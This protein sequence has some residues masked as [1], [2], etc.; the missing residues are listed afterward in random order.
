VLE[1][2]GRVLVVRDDLIPG[3][4]KTR[5]LPIL[6]E[7]TTDEVVYATPAYGHAQIALAVT[8]QRMGKRLTL[9][10]AE[11]KTYTP[12]TIK[13]LSLGADMVAIP[14]GY[15]SN[16]QSKAMNYATSKGVTLLPF[17]L[18]CEP[19]IA[20]LTDVVRSLNVT[21]K[22]VWAA[23]GSGTLARALQRAWPDAKHRVVVVGARSDFGTAEVLV[24]PE[25]YDQ[26]A[27]NPPPFPSAAHYD[28]KVWQFIRQ[29]PDDPKPLFWNVAG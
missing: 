26:K 18:L 11:R 19:F 22:T 24:A 4:T 27:S 8:C 20:A 7:T 13:A 23:G 1:L 17:G 29:H 2:H 15:L 14:Y 28:A 9:F 10:T 6:L 16:V 5:A 3:G 21:P 25:R 12:M